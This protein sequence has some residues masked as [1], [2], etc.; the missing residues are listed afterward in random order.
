MR[1]VGGWVG[2]AVLALALLAAIVG[3]VL[4]V[5]SRSS[6]PAMPSF[7]P[8]QWAEF[9]T[10]AGHRVHV[11][12][13][14]LPCASCHDL[15]RGGF[16]APG[17]EVC[18]SCHEKQAD[19][20]H[21]GGAGADATSC[22]TCHAFAPGVAEPKCIG[23]HDRPHGQAAAIG[24]HATTDCTA[25]HRLHESPSIVPADCTHCHDERA[26]EHAAHAGSKSCLDCHRPHAPAAA[27]LETCSS[28][29]AQPAGPHP[30][31]HASCTGCH[32]PHAFAAGGDRACLRC[33]GEKPTLAADVV[34]AHA[35]CTSCHTPHAPMTA[36]SSCVRCH[37][38]VH[39][40]HADRGACVTCHTPHA[41][42]PAPVASA[43]SS[44]HATVA[45]NDHAAHAGDVAC[46]ACHVRHG[47]AVH[48]PA[49]ICARCHAGEVSLAAT[50][51]GHSSCPSCHGKAV[52][53]APAKPPACVT[54]HAKEQATAPQGH[55]SCTACHDKHAGLPA[56]PCAT[57]HAREAATTHGELPDGCEKCHR[58]HGP[59]GASAPPACT[60]CHE[61]ATL[62][63]LH[64][65]G[66]HADCQGCHVTPHAPP[67]EERSFCTATCHT[68]RRDHQPQAQVCT[69]CH[70]FRK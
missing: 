63:A 56:P 34:P 12:R 59:G 1:R 70:V 11:E 35:S 55:S 14:K 24:P 52:A 49:A 64:Q 3:A 8:P 42:S 54:C 60:T 23:C 4:H 26:T 51:P 29:H 43:C 58:P 53:H 25:C 22:F 30:A 28:C 6:A 47:F 2:A 20:A 10:S 16:S 68:D 17:P 69:G 13:A 27:A 67:R 9:R 48:E 50:N 61:R 66:A 31:D 18:R 46:T 36:A 19:H 33:H 40:D 38:G 41:A 5:R 45:A 44:C 32:Q 37:A 65:I 21:R 39:V 7:V 57:C 15:S 62:P